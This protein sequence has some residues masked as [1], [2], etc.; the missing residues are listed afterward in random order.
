VRA[1]TML[2]TRLQLSPGSRSPSRLHRLMLL[3]HSRCSAKVLPLRN[4]LRLFL[5]PPLRRPTARQLFARRE[6][7]G[8]ADAY[9]YSAFQRDNSRLEGPPPGRAPLSSGLI[10]LLLGSAP[11]CHKNLSR[12]KKRTGT[13]TF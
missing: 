10:S 5:L 8:F 12:K 4:L 3:I 6:F 11:S 2:R 13:R 9:N 1:G 7:L